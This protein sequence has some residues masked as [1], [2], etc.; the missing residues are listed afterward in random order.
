MDPVSATSGIVGLIA[1]AFKTIQL[2]GEYV[3]L[4]NEHKKHAETLH[5]ELLLMKQVLDQLKDLINEE[6]R[7]GR[8][9][10]VGDE[11]RHT[12]L[13]KA[14]SDCTKT[15]EQIQD[16]LKEP[17]NKF[18]KAMAKMKWPFEQKDV[19]RM[20][21]SLRRYTQ[22]FQLSLTEANRKLLCKTFEAASEGLKSQRDNCK[23]IRRL[24]ADVPQM[25]TAAESTL[26]QTETLLSLIPTLL[27]EVSSDIKEIGVTQQAAERREQGKHFC[28]LSSRGSQGNCA[29]RKENYVDYAAFSA[30]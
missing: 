11:D 30:L 21:D 29:N 15:I 9:T 22:L 7:S 28:T 20:V 14:F 1:V 24:W 10:S 4:A 27:Q 17:T 12:V 16:K 25:A 5:K 6:K 18:Q 19:L 3:N 2:V 23:E 13:G 8:L 26:K